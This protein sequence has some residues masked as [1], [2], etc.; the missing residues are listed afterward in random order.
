MLGLYFS[1]RT[2]ESTAT[3]QPATSVVTTAPLAAQPTQPEASVATVPTTISEVPET[4]VK[5]LEISKKTTKNKSIAAKPELANQASRLANK[6]AQESQP[7]PGI[8][9][10]IVVKNSG[11][12]TLLP[13]IKAK[14][15]D[16]Q[17]TTEKLRQEGAVAWK[18]NLTPLTHKPIRSKTRVTL[19]S[20][21]KK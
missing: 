21:M 14:T 19:P 15:D 6:Q 4:K 2:T 7:I 3:Q 11:E 17:N 9:P 10:I 5:P 18:K 16:P 8:N 1:L 13:G 12:A 20:W